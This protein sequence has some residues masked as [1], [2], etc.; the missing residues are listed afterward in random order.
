MTLSLHE[1]GA[2]FIRYEVK[3][4]PYERAVGDPETWRERGCP[5]EPVVGP[6]EAHYRVEQLL[7]ADG[8]MFLCPKC[9]YANDGPAGTHWVICWFAGKV[10]PDAQPGPGRWFPAGSGLADLSFVG[11]GSTSV[12]L[13]SGCGWHGHVRNGEVTLI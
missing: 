10:P 12:H 4:E 2:Y 6:R 7:Q 1:L 5:T 13:R 8:V 11:T 3:H 9:F